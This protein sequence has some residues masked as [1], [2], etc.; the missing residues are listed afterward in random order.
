MGIPKY[1]EELSFMLTISNEGQI[2]QVF[3]VYKNGATDGFPKGD[4]ISISNSI[5]LF[6]HEAYVRGETI[7][8]KIAE[9]LNTDEIKE[10]VKNHKEKSLL[11][12]KDPI[13]E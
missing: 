13:D 6:I 11:P 7:G 5:P 4:N 8:R 12:E 2:D 3:K 9:F 1:E 10:L